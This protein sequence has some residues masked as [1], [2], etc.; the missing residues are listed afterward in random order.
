MINT[1]CARERCNV[2]EREMFKK[3]LASALALAAS[4][5]MA[6]EYKDYTAT[7]EIWSVTFVNVNPNRMDDYL[8]GLKQTWV[9]VCEEGKKAGIML[10][11]SIMVSNTAYSRD[12]NVMLIQKVPSAAVSDP[13]EAMYRKIDAALKARLAQDKRN[14]IVTNYESMRTMFGS[15]DFRKIIYK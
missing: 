1:L 7:K 15:Q 6:E 8:M 14:A 5:A 13:D 10:D 9:P 12:F 2:E 3:V 4:G 11:C